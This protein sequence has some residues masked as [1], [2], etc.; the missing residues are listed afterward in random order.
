MAITR[1]KGGLS[2][3]E[4]AGLRAAVDA[5]RKPKVTFTA[6]AGQIAGRTG[7]VVRLDDPGASEEWVVVR[8]GKDELPFAPSDLELPQRKV[9]VPAKRA[10]AVP[11][12][13]PA[14]RAEKVE[15]IEPPQWTPAAVEAE[16]SRPAAKPE[17]VSSVVPARPA[18]RKSTA[19]KSAAPELM[20]T[21]SCHDGQW[22]VAAHKGAKAL[23]KSVPVRASEALKMVQLLD[24]PPVQSVVEEIVEAARIDAEHQAER[25]R[26]ELKRVEAA[27]ADLRDI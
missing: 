19:K 17:P 2:E 23:V 11:A 21:I 1:I 5:G 14:P 3:P 6:A 20:V 18:A 7:Q 16:P 15:Q 8:F 10:T 26:E 27:L 22:S 13:V 25:L 24:A 12:P 9:A 4:L